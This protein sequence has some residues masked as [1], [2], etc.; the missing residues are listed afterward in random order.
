MAWGMDAM[1]WEPWERACLS[2]TMM[3]VLGGSSG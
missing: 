3:F 2:L 1:W